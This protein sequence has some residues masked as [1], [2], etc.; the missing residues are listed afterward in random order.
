MKYLLTV[1]LSLFVLGIQTDL[2]AQG[3]R[4]GLAPQGGGGDQQAGGRQAGGQ[5]GRG[6]Q[7]GARGAAEDP[8]GTAT[9]R[10][11]VL[12]TDTGAPVRRAQVRAVAAG[13]RGN[14]LVTTDEQGMFELRDLP[15]GR[16]NVTASKAGFVTMSF[17]QR[18][19]FEAGRPIELSGAQTLERVDLVLPRGAAITGRLVDEFGDPVARARV[20]AQRYQLVQGTRRLTPVG[21]TAQ[22]DDTGAFRLYGLMP[23]EYYVSAVLRALPVDDPDDTMSYAPTYYPGTGSVTEAQP[24]SL[25]LGAEA[26]VSFALMPVVTA[27]ITGSVLSSTGAP[28]SN[29]RV[30][31]T[32]ANSPG[33]PAAA[34]GSGGRVQSDGTFSLS[35]VAPG[36]YTLTALSGR[37]RNAGPDA[38]RG[39]API[40]VAGED[41]TSVMVIT[42]RG[43]TLTGTVSGGWGTTEQPPTRRVRIAAQ[44]VPF[45]PTPRSRPARVDTDGTFTLTNLFGPNI[46][47]VSGLP[48]EWMVEAILVAGSDV[49]D[50]P[51]DF[52]P[53]QA[54][55]HAEIV[56]TDRVT[57]VSGTVRERS[58]APSID[59]TLVVFPEDDTKW[60]P[61]SRFVRSARPDQQ[62][63]VKILGLPPDVRYLAAAVDY[64]EEGGASDPAFLN[65]IKGRASRF[66]L[67]PGASVTVDLTLVE[68]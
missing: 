12:A 55:E 62:G 17:G 53:N 1:T 3:G 27:R 28:L 41:L 59:F 23:G 14:R 11:R 50:T 36:S 54:I 56:L 51:F 24:V 35:N 66:S 67:D 37:G 40:T 65:E 46:L 19:P 31:L 44:P 25:D 38:E 39:S 9:I 22:S 58:G 63:L 21:V 60:T 4:G 48:S 42:S 6:Q 7:P 8:A 52:R 26:S 2:F 16:W 64:V 29:A 10:G 13:R 43:A 49:T 18:R 15:T 57:Q 34:F 20:R 32:A 61:Q 33:M 30:T 47:R 68:R 5:Q 45:D